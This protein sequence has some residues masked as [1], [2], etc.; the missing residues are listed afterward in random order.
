MG[1]M[2]GVVE[3]LWVRNMSALC[4]TWQSMFPQATSAGLRDW[5]MRTARRELLLMQGS[6]MVASLAARLPP[7]F[8]SSARPGCC[9]PWKLSH[10]PSLGMK[11]V[12]CLSG[13]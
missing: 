13:V 12:R 10:V 1:C 4:S 7:G 5:E 6:H 11:L 2:A 3:Q 8:L 9:N